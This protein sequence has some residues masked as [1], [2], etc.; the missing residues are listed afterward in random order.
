MQR[1][2]IRNS[3]DYHQAVLEALA[4]ERA[5]ALGR[6][7]RRLEEAVDTHRLLVEV[8]RAEDQQIAA[9]LRAVRDAAWALMVQRECAGFRSKDLAWLRTHYRVP[10]EVLRRL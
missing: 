2:G 7:G 5:N 8:G 1:R 10:A 4:G 9:S 3:R 6:A